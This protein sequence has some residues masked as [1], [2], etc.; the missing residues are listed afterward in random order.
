MLVIQID[1]FSLRES[2]ELQQEHGKG[3]SYHQGKLSGKNKNSNE[4]V[5]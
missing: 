4:A 3:N 1:N 2:K 5:N